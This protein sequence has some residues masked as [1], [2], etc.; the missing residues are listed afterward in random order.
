[1]V[2][3][4]GIVKEGTANVFIK[5]GVGKNQKVTRKVVK[6]IDRTVEETDKLI[7]EMFK[8]EK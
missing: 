8:E 5:E 2:R 6:T 4:G 7:S 3:E 1:M